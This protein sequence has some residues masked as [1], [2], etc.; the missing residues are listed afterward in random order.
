[1]LRTRIIATTA[2]VLV[3]SAVFATLMVF[4]NRA[5]TFV[6]PFRVEAGEAAPVTLRIPWTRLMRTGDDTSSIHLEARA[7]IVA[8]GEVVSEPELGSLVRA[9]E[10]GRRP[11]DSADLLGLW[12]VYFLISMMLT[13]YLRGL[14]P[15][16][17]ALLRTQLGLMALTLALLLVAKVFLLLTPFP[18]HVV[19]VAAMSLWAALFLDRRT[20]L[21]VGLAMAFLAASLVA[22]RLAVAAVYL[23]TS[24]TSVL[25]LGDKKNNARI[26]QSGVAAALAGAG[27]YVAARVIFD[28]GFDLGAEL[29]SPWE[30]ALLASIVG[31]LVSGVVAWAASGLAVMVLGSVS[32]AK[33]VELSDLDQPLLKKIAKEAP[34]SW[35]HSRAMAN[36]AEA[37]ANAIGADA[38]LTRVGAYYHDLGK[39]CQAKYFVENLQPGEPTPHREIPPDL[40][41]DAIMA[42]V[43]EGV[44]IL[45]RG[46][47]PE[48]VVEFA[49]THHGTSVIEYFWHKT[50]EQGNPRE[51]DE[52]FFRYPGMR[53]RTK[54]TA[55][56]MLVDSIEAASRTIDPPERDKFEEMVQRIIFVKLRQGQLDESGLTLQELRTIAN[57]V[58]DSLCS[59]YHSRIKYPWQEKKKDGSEG[60]LPL[61]G[62]A[63][64]EEVAKA[65]AEAAAR[66][67]AAAREEA[68]ESAEP[69]P[70]TTDSQPPE[71]RPEAP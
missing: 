40:S 70:S 66:E 29:R 32:R 39:S 37:A 4:V 26:V 56:L 67:K 28:G 57:Q 34:G 49:Y 59:I 55:I 27:V 33:L 13:A 65:R 46:N 35:E 62:S 54:E 52:S 23:A 6:E 25:V 12:F 64:E 24:I 19:P 20:A 51:R 1:M 9:Y 14:S 58:V 3:V 53:P 38:L 43:V 8:R 42:H 11:P 68:D 41:A 21:M 10:D 5:E 61:P 44:N 2:T 7:P 48:P 31:G 47:I 22:F 69:E 71:P 30:S 15:G 50:I 63:T 36:L 45:R 17:G 16:R 18:A 60:G